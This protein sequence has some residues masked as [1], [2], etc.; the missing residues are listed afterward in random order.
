MRRAA[1]TDWA[2]RTVRRGGTAQWRVS[3][4]RARRH[5]VELVGAGWSLH[6]IA[7]AAGV[8]VATVHRVLHARQ[9]SNL[10]ADALRAVELVTPNGVTPAPHGAMT[11]MSANG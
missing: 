6:R 4:D 7:T 11:P 3:T 2:L 8:S 10:T 1:R 9:C 5:V